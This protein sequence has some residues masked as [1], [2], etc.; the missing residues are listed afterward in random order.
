[1]SNDTDGDLI[2]LDDFAKRQFICDDFGDDT[3]AGTKIPVPANDFMARV[4]AHVRAHGIPSAAQGLL[5]DG[6]AP[7]CKHVFIP[8]FDDRIVDPAVRIT[9]ANEHQ[10]RTCYEAR[11]PDELPVLIRFF[12]ADGDVKPAPA[13]Y[14]DLILYSREQI[15]KERE[16]MGQPP[17]PPSET[18]P[19]R[20]ISVKAQS[21]PY[22]IPM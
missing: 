12:P 10:L 2:V 14:L 19:W 11:T 7:F 8:N 6:Y 5:V 21:V 20:L 15:V 13:T 16:A 22:E 4:H 17:V 9:S 3:Y 1:M 18:Q